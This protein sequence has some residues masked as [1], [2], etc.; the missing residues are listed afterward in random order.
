VL[1]SR[2]LRVEVAMEVS[3]L[4]VEEVEVASPEAQVETEETE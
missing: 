1:D 2:R 3:A 4:V